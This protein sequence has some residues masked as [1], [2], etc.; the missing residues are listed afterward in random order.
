MAVK[1]TCIEKDN[2]NHYNPHEAISTLGWF[3]E[4]NS[5][6]GR[7]SRLEMVKFIEDGNQAY[8]VDVYRNKVYLVV[9]V[10][11]G[12]N[13]YVQTQTDGRLTNNLLELPEC[14]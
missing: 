10:S 4:Y 11:V 14:R 7:C 5:Q 2:G 3:N 6:S 12:N 1:I 13:K 9:K 8:V